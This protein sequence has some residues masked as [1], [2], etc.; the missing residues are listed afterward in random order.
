MLSTT[1]SF[2]RERTGARR[3]AMLAIAAVTYF[4]LVIVVLHVLRPDLNPIRQPTSEYAVGPFG[5]LMT[6]AFFS[7]S[8]A[9]WA[10]LIG[11]RQGLPPAARSRLG[12]GLLALWGVG[13]LIAMSFPIDAEGA[14]QTLS[15]TIHQTNGPVVFFCLAVGAVLISRRLKRADAWRPLYWPALVLS[16]LMLVEFVVTGAAMG[17]QSGFGGLAQRILLVTF[18]AWFFL[19]ASRLRALAAQ[20]SEPER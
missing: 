16:L 13:V 6:T 20:S 3:L 18:L 17:T 9:T 14:P 4:A 8:V 12:L 11:L 5:S 15:G 2:N 19:M 1:R 10:L 7:I